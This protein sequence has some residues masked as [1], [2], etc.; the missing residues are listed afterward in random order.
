M[1]CIMHVF[2]ISG[3]PDV[4]IVTE[5]DQ[6]VRLAVSSIRIILEPDEIAIQHVSTVWCLIKMC[7][8]PR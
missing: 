5:F 2:G 8:P 1:M 4:E 3:Q 6:V 7:V